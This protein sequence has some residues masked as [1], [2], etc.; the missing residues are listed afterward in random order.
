[1]IH[2]WS[3][4]AGEFVTVSCAA[5][6]D[7]LIDSELFGHRRG[8]FAAADENL[9]GVVEQAEGGTLF[10]DGIADLSLNSQGKLLRLIEHGEIHPIGASQPERLDV[11]I[12]A[13]TNRKLKEDVERGRFREELFYRL[14]TFHIEIPPLRERV[15]DISVI[16][17][18]L[19]K[20]VNER[21]STRVAFTPE[22][23]ETIRR[24]PLKGNVL[25]LRSLIERTVLTADESAI[26][27]PEAIERVTVRQTE[28]AGRM[29]HW[30]GCS[31]ETE[32]RRYEGDLIRHA[33]EAEKGSVTRAARLLGVS[34]QGLAFI[35]HGRQ[36]ELLHERTPV[37]RRR[38][39]ILGTARR[40]RQK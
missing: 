27:T 1:M 6:S 3:G 4:R 22:A 32:V 16:A 25:E 11:R 5:L 23:M 20:E 39:S 28:E 18:H 36:K 30:E 33:L 40:K 34:H 21:Y 13:S 15:A 31:L 9:P 12:I 24:L 8:S 37:K 14:Q 35:L 2:E 26:V 17:E 10:L 38:R 19:I 7:G 29:S